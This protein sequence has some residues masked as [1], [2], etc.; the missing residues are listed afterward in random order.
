MFFS[1][2]AAAY[3]LWEIWQRRLWGLPRLWLQLIA[4]ALVVSA[5]TVPLLLP[6]AMVQEQLQIARSRGELSMYAAD[7]YSYATAVRDMAPRD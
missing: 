7:V 4:A 1:P 5:V 3:V 6:Y 2:F